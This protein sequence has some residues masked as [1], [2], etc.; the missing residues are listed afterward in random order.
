MMVTQLSRTLL[1]LSLSAVI[2]RSEA[3]HMP[4]RQSA[5]NNNHIFAV[6]QSFMPASW[7]NRDCVHR[8]AELQC[9][10]ALQERCVP[11]NGSDTYDPSCTRDPSPLTGTFCSSQNLSGRTSTDIEL[12]VLGSEG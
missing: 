8:T 3:V 5:S 12:G 11:D 9:V 6:E 7:A 2:C 4:S 1:S 10:T